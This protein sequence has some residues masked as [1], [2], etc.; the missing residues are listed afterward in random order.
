MAKSSKS[1]IYEE[2]DGIK[3]ID[4]NPE[5]SKDEYAQLAVSDPDVLEALISSLCGDGRRV[6]Q[7]SATIL[8]QVARTNPSLLVSSIE[9]LEDAL[10]RPEA[11]T[12]WNVLDAMYELVSFDLDGC[13]DAM[14]GAEASLYDEDSGLA[15]LS[16]FR[17][18]CRLGEED[19]GASEKV[20]PYIDEAV[21]C[22]HGD[23]EFN[24]MLDELLK[25]ARSKASAD[26][27]AKLIDRMRF[28]ADSGKGTLQKRAQAI[29]EA[30]EQG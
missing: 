18:M 14:V 24:E 3:R 8:S 17:F 9:K 29:I 4:V 7:F 28:D 26:V 5:V 23:P 20:W 15:R 12:R 21:Q 11:Q 30:C 19:A 22:Y 13:M 10:H 1:R 25:F 16:A 2:V 27:K 6:R